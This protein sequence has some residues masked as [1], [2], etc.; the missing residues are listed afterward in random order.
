[1]VQGETIQL[2]LDLLPLQVD[3]VVLV[4]SPL[5]FICLNVRTHVIEMNFDGFCNSALS[6][7]VFVIYADSEVFAGKF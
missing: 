1:M 5:I 6:G 3:F 7:L 4:F 2:Y